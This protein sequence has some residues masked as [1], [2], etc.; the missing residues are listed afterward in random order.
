M[1]NHIGAICAG[2]AVL[3]TCASG[4]AAATDP[5][6]RSVVEAINDVRAQHGLRPLRLAPGLAASA[7]RW[8]GSQL[9]SDYFGHA[10]SI[11]APGR[12]RTLGEV[13]FMHSGTRPHVGAAVSGW[14]HSTAHAQILLTPRFRYV[15]AGRAS[16]TFQGRPAT[17]WT[18]QLGA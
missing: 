10:S 18:V 3:L 1:R 9:R 8:S 11:R 5:A 13:L 14:M 7:G 2:L 17:I 4:A 15:G 6:E 16:G 12:F